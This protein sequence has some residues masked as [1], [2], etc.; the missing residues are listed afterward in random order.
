MTLRNGD[1]EWGLSVLTLGLEKD[2]SPPRASGRL[3]GVAARMALPLSAWRIN[4]GWA[5]LDALPAAGTANLMGCE[6]GVFPFRQL[7]R[8]D[9]AAPDDHHQ[10]VVDP[11]P[12]TLVGISVMSQLQT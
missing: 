1:S 7:P 2:P 6:W 9:L 10:I 11:D 8:H 3:S 5:P 4:G 12:C